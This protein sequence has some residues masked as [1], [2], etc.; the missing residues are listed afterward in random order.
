MA[1]TRIV[2]P[3]VP[4]FLWSIGK[5]VKRRLSRS[6]DH[7]A[8]AP[9]GWQTPLPP[10]EGNETYWTTF[11]AQERVLC[12][13]LIERVRAGNPVLTS[14]D[15]MVNYVIFGYVLALAARRKDQLTV[16]DYGGNL[17][18]FY[19]I[20]KALLPDLDLEYHCKELPEVAAAGCL[21]TPDVIWHTDDTCLAASY[22]LVVFF[23]SLPYLRD[24]TDVLARAAQATRHYLFL[25]VPSIR[26]V[27]TFV[28]TQRSGG[29]TNLQYLFNGSEIV[30]TAQ[31]AG[32]RL[33]REFA[34]GP[35]PPVANAPEQPM[36]V[37]WLFARESAAR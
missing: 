11:V 2:K 12:Q 15:E 7:Y 20:G 8:Y 5:D 10:G 27:P 35:H 16:I 34:M 21:L 17:G 14:D 13:E 30:D 29:V 23:G 3:I 1:F 37:G 4:P 33:V 36:Y 26:S 19:W 25:S 6:V 24:W 9:R 18:D 32:L 22:D 31:R 28:I